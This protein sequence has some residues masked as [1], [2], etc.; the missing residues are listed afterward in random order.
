LR[1]NPVGLARD[2]LVEVSGGD[3]NT[4]VVTD[5]DTELHAIV[6]APTGTLVFHPRTS[7]RGAFAAHDMQINAD[8]L[9]VYESGFT[10]PLKSCIAGFQIPPDKV[11]PGKDPQDLAHTIAATACLAPDASSCE[12][13]FLAEA[14]FDRRS[15]AKQLVAGLFT[16]ARYVAVSRDRTR[17]LLRGDADPT[18]IA[19]LCRGDSDGD[20]VPDDRDACPGTPS[21]TA[22][23]DR[24]C[25]D[26]NLPAAPD[27]V[28]M[29]KVF[30]NAGIMIGGGCDGAPEPSAPIVTD[31]CLDRPNL[32]FLITVSQ[33][34]RQP[35]SCLVWYQMNTASVEEGEPDE[36]FR[37]F[38][39]FERGQAV[40]QTATSLTLPVPL[41][42]DPTVETKG[43]GRSWPCDEVDGDPYNTL[44][45]ARAINGNGQ[46]SSWGQARDF[47]FHLCP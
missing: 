39:A 17:K 12:I 8:A 13:M 27:P 5:S 37:A 19:A 16:P 21:L 6:S 3:S 2:L 36:N 46:Q 20:L 42:C 28:K 22:T 45:A 33:D 41:T 43:D 26:P 40:T 9:V 29:K 31:V 35:A 7:A 1:T 24:G 44:I 38:L 14:N 23:D 11:V 47:A 4:A 10:L 32:R 25:T 15:A 30:D 18:W 34:P